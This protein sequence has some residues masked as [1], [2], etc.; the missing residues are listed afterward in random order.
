[1]ATTCAVCNRPIADYYFEAG[2]KVLCPNC[3]Q[4]IAASMTG[5]SGFLRFLKA[6]A[7]GAIGGLAG[8]AL[9]Y[10]VRRATGYEVGI[11]AIVVGFLVGGAVRKGSGN[12]G[13]VGYQILAVLL[14][15]VAVSLNY[16]PD[17][18]KVFSEKDGGDMPAAVVFVIA[19]VVSLGAPFL[20]G[21]SNIIGLVIIGFALWEA[22]KI[23]KHRPV[24]FNGP[25]RVAPTG[26]MQPAGAPMYAQMPGYPAPGYPTPGAPAYAPPPGPGAW[27]PPPPGGA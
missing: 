23:N 5:G 8:A 14:T 27:P 10:G 7:L 2:G 22:W 25:Y 12:R 6:L 4:M 3:Q 17:V 20:M 15:Y 9:W 1:V 11:I 26:G 16:L 24:V 18:Y 13:G 21:V 19:A